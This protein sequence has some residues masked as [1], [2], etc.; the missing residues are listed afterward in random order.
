LGKE[1][2]AI[3]EAVADHLRRHFRRSPEKIHLIRNGINLAHAIPSIRQTPN[4]MRV[5]V[6]GRLSGGRWPAIQF[7]LETL[8]RTAKTLPPAHYKLSVEFP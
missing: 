2:I 7:F 4:M 8:E 1:T 3:D 5:L 6:I